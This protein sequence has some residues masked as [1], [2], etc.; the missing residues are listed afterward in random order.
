MGYNRAEAKDTRL[1]KEQQRSRPITE[2]ESN[3]WL[4]TMENA[5]RGI[6]AN[7]KMIHVCDR[8][9]DMAN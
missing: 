9:G 3:R 5:N 6:P 4:E 7:V 8:E 1:T 2:K